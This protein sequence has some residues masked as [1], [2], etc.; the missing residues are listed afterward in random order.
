MG[1]QDVSDETSRREPVFD[2]PPSIGLLAAILV[3]IHLGRSLV[4]A[5]TDEWIIAVLGFMPLRYEGPIEEW[6]GG[7]ASALLSPF[8]HFFVH[9]DLTHLFINVTM[10]L[11]FGGLVGRR[12]DAARL[13]GFIALCS[14]VGAGLFYLVNPGAAATMI[15]ASGGISGLMAAALRLMFSAMDA[16][17]GR[18][19][20][21]I[22]RHATQFIP[23]QPL[24]EALGDRRIR[25]ATGL[26]LAVNLLAALGLGTPPDAGAIAWEAHVGGFLA[27]ML[28][29]GAFDNGPRGGADYAEPDDL[30]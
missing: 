7:W 3:A 23:L 6:P 21:E 14:A 9:G 28:L 11:A 5:R 16:S 20:G 17:P 24:R 30:E 13:F 1:H 26:W 18:G 15:G 29:Y 12:I 25:L 8:S 22:I 2:V 4:S 27:G 19:A 10:L